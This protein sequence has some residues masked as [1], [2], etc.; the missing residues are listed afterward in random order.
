LGEVLQY[1]VILVRNELGLPNPMRTADRDTLEQ[2]ILPAYAARSDVRSVLFV[3]CAWYS[4][5][6]ETMFSRQAYWTLDPDPW[7]KRFGSR[8][9]HVVAGLERI[10]AHFPEGSLD[11]IV[12]NGVFGWGLDERDDCERAFAGCFE[13]LR[14]RGELVI[15][16]N[17]VAEHRPLALNSLQSLARFERLEFQALGT[18]QSLANAENGHVFNFYVKP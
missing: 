17:D 14:P 13:A 11:L 4:S 15:G 5:H 9:R 3:G 8:R 18:A 1:G 7:K 2:V 12:C 6:Y 10:D 16:W